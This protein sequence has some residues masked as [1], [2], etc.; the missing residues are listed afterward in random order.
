MA[1]RA[2]LPILKRPMLKIVRDPL[3]TGTLPSWRA[4]GVSVGTTFLAA[5]FAIVILG[6]LQRKVVLYL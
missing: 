1:A 3:V 2:S 6:R 4:Y 5:A